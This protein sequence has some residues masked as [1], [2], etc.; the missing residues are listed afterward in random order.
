M[1][2]GISVAESYR[3]LFD[4]ATG[5]RKLLTPK[6][7]DKVSYGGGEFSGDGKAVYITS[8]RG[9]EFHRLV[10]LDLATGE[11]KVLTPNVNWDVDNF[12]VSPDGKT[13]AFVTNEDGADVLRLLDTATGREKA[14]PKL[15]LGLG[16]MG[17]VRWHEKGACWLSP[18]PPRD[19]PRTCTASSRHPEKSSGGPR[20]RRAG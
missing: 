9:S 19:H 3:W 8:D 7:G 1:S 12:D 13:I 18:S 15:G 10:R 20:A 2:E 4:T 5:E 17:G 14:A 16:T 6:G 11:N